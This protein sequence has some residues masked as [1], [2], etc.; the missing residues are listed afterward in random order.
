MKTM[1]DFC[2]FGPGE[3]LFL[4]GDRGDFMFMLREGTVDV[5]IA[6]PELGNRG[7]SVR[8]ATLSSGDPVGE[9]ALILPGSS[10]IATVRATSHVIAEKVTREE[11]SKILADLRGR[12]PFLHTMFMALAKRVADTTQKLVPKS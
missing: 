2:A 11:F 6:A 3:A 8:V 9:L 7:E 10:R 1:N 4:Q 5:E 12:S